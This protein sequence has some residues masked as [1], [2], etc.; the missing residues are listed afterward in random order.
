MIFQS[1][2][3]SASGG[4]TATLGTPAQG[5]PL[6]SIPRQ[7]QAPCSGFLSDLDPQIRSP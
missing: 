7:N 4:S 2:T 5:F 3:L 1:L 6:L